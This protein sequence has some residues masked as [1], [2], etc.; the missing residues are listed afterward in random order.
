MVIG[1]AL[2]A[3]G[4]VT[5]EGTLRSARI[6]ARLTDALLETP[7]PIL[8]PHIRPLHR[9]A[10]VDR[11]VAVVGLGYVG[12]P[13]ALSLLEAGCRVIGVDV[14]TARLNAIARQDVGL[15]SEERRVGKGVR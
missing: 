3:T 6:E 8:G 9:T 11:T 7:T 10:D 15:R 2:T 1:S 4:L 14:S 5:S 13:T 12:L